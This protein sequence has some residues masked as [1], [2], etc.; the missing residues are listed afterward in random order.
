MALVHSRVRRIF[1]CL[2]HEH[3]AL[4]SCLKLHGIASLNHRQARSS[5]SPPCILPVP[6]FVARECDGWLCGG[7]RYL[8]F[9]RLLAD[10]CRQALAHD[11]THQSSSKATASSQ[12]P[13]SGTARPAA[14][15]PRLAV[16]ACMQ[17]LTWRGL[18]PS[19]CALR[20]AAGPCGLLRGGPGL[21]GARQHRQQQQQ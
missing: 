9:R 19:V 14:A 7:G 12:G 11:I 3:G 20:A 16:M 8:V 21:G 2:P 15:A 18:P 1:Y 5:P 10:E 6:S 4:G 13:V 17:L